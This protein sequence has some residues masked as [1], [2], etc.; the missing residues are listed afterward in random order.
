M[1][2]PVPPVS[3]GASEHLRAPLGELEL[4]EAGK[5]SS[6]HLCSFPKSFQT[7][8]DLNLDVTMKM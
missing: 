7:L 5:G 8:L 3:Q 4:G 1:L 2:E 6:G